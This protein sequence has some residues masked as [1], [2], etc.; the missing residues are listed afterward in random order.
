M[1][2]FDLK[3]KSVEVKT[4]TRP[5]RT[6]WTAEMAADLSSYHNIDTSKMESILMKEMRVYKRK[7]MIRKIY[8]S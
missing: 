6:Q 5:I 8:E 2:S 4:T 3:M 1:K 7:S